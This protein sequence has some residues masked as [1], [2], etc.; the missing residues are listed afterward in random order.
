MGEAKA[1]IVGSREIFESEVE[2]GVTLLQPV[3]IEGI[4]RMIEI[5]NINLVFMI[6]FP[7]HWTGSKRA[8][9]WRISS[10]ANEM[11]YPFKLVARLATVLIVSIT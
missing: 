5:I 11:W 1:S 8:V 6:S 9:K 4:S 7:G 3:I 2:V 10:G